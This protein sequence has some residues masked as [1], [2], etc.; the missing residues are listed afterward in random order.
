MLDAY[1]HP[2]GVHLAVWCPHERR[3][4]Q[5][6]I[7]RRVEGCANRDRS[8]FGAPGCTC[9]AGSGDGHR[10][11]HCTCRQSPLGGG[12]YL[13]EVGEYGPE[14][15]NYV[16]EDTSVSW[17]CPTW[18]GYPCTWCSE[19]GRCSCE[20]V[21]CPEDSFCAEHADTGCE[22]CWKTHGGPGYGHCETHGIVA[23][24]PHPDHKLCRANFDG[25]CETS[26]LVTQYWATDSVRHAHC[27]ACW[28]LNALRARDEE[29][30][31]WFAMPPCKGC[32]ALV[33]EN[34]LG[35]IA[36][37]IENETELVT[38]LR[39]E[40]DA[41]PDEEKKALTDGLMAAF[42]ADLERYQLPTCPG[43]I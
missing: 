38:S 8:D 34:Q 22:S 17:A 10:G 9:P 37:Q 29:T 16:D 41:R 30:G 36:A 11:A 35:R 23:M 7:C 18:A 40:W 1:R 25:S 6:G 42:D 26:Y 27:P 43:R 21:K 5:H 4:H 24:H 12:Y 2:D 33:N 31:Q 19:R 28:A 3:W 20:Q 14:V 32:R 13:R 39:A 15:P